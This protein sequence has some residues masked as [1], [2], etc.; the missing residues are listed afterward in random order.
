MSSNHSHPPPLAVWLLRA[1][2]HHEVRYAVEGDYEETYVWL[3][4]QEGEQAARRWYWRQV[5]RSI[6]L[7]FFDTIYWHTRMFKN[8]LTVARRH[9]AKHKGYAFINLTGLAVGIACCLLILLYVRDE[10]RYDRFHEKA[11]RIHRLVV[12]WERSDQTFSNSL[13]SAP[14]AVTVADNYPGVEAYVRFLPEA[15]DMLVANGEQRFYET[16]F[17]YADASVFEVFSFPLKQGQANDVLVRPHTMVISESMAAKY[18]GAD[19]PIGQKLDVDN[20]LSFEVTGVMAD[21]PMQSHMRFDFLA[22]FA[23]LETR[24]DLNLD[25]WTNNPYYSYLLLHE[26]ASVADLE[27]Q[28]PVLIETHVGEALENMGVA[29]RFWL[30][31]LTDIHLFPLG[32][33]LS[34][35]GSMQFVYIFVGVALFILLIAC[36]NFINLSTARAT[37]RAKEVGL[38]KVIGAHR[39][40]LVLQFLGE[41]VLLTLGAVVLAVALLW[42]ALPVFNALVDKTL[43]VSW[44]IATVISLVVL[45]VLVGVVAGSYPALWMSRFQPVETLKGMLGRKRQGKGTLLVR[46]GLVVFQF[47]TSVFLIVATLVVYRQVD[48]MQT[49]NLGL[50]PEQVVVLPMRD[51]SLR[52]NYAAVRE[53]LLAIPAVQHVAVS[54]RKPG[55]G[56]GGSTFRRASEPEATMTSMKVMVTDHHFNQTLAIDVVAGRDFSEAFVT[57]AEDG[58]LLNQQAATDLGW[59]NPEEAIGQRVQWGGWRSFEVVGI[60]DNFHFQPLSVFMQPL[61]MIVYPSLAEHMLIR[62]QTTDWPQTLAQLEE[63]WATLVPDWPFVYSFLDQDYAQLYAREEQFGQLFIYFAGLSLLVACLGLFGLASFSVERRIKE[64]G[65]RKVLGATTTH[66][67][68]LLSREFA[69]LVGVACVVAWP[70]AYVAADAWLQAYAFRA[71]LALWLFGM[72]ALGALLIA[73]LTTSYHAVRASRANPVETLRYE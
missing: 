63:T 66:L 34:P 54:N 42:L 13:S 12:D 28:F 40:Q 15:R 65:I 71:E 38:R 33:E 73:W 50:T 16:Q 35:G 44:D 56:A 14:M 53:Q 62:T 11:E 3:A 17:T 60:V 64:M 61:V 18:F 57:D 70:L 58:M 30:Q 46:R 23:S 1:V 25:N 29:W 51:A 52:E 27:A 7:Y 39:S 5:L 24:E 31:P 19:D 10:L 45:L 49:K 69:L 2:T 37:T 36:I 72:A 47:A 26:D 4:E 55:T 67:A 6:P 9:L 59:A 22:S 43:V 41:S 8:Y 48:Y 68:L 20:N 32:N 21:M